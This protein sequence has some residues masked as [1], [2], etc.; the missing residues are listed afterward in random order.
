MPIARQGSSASIG[1]AAKGARV[2][3]CEIL[4][5]GP[6]LHFTDLNDLASESY[7]ITSGTQTLD[8]PPEIDAGRVILHRFLGGRPNVAFYRLERFSF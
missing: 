8:L 4:G 5:G 7:L 1:A 2:G 6:M 3:L